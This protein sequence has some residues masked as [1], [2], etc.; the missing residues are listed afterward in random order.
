MKNEH[1]IKLNIFYV[2]MQVYMLRNLSLC[3]TDFNWL[4]HRNILIYLIKHKLLI[5]MNKTLINYLAFC[6][7]TKNF[8]CIHSGI[9][10][11]QR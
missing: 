7:Q 9:N 5:S 4:T 6:L 11:S 8:K 1:Y 2:K 10:D 3:W